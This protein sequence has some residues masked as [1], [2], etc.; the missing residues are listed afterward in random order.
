MLLPKGDHEVDPPV[1]LVFLGTGGAARAKELT[2]PQDQ[3]V[4]V[5]R[6]NRQ[7]TQLGSV[8]LSAIF[9]I[10]FVYKFKLH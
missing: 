5:F 8:I 2:P 9:K 3:S 1:L 6:G 7:Q 10:Y 4:S